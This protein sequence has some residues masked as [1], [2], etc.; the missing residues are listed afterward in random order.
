MPRGARVAQ[1]DRR[2]LLVRLTEAGRT[3]VDEVL[4]VSLNEQRR[5]LET[6]SAADRERLA[7]LLRDLL[8]AVEGS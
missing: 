1:P 7:G 8:L 3:L 4:E 2:A 5:W 6:L